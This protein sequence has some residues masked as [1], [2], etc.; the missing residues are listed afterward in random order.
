LELLQDFDFPIS[1]GKIR[2]TPDGKF[3]LASG[4]K[5]I[6]PPHISPVALTSEKSPR[7]GIYP[8]QIRIYEAAELSMKV[9]RH[10]DCEIVNFEV[11]SNDYSKLVLLRADR[12][13]EFHA[14]YGMYYET[15]I[16]KAGRDIAYHYPTCDLFAVGSTNEIYRLNLEQG[17]FLKP[18]ESSSPAVNVCGVN[19]A[20]GW[21]GFGGSDGT[22]ECWDPRDK[23]CSAALPITRKTLEAAQLMVAPQANVEISSFRWSN[24][25]IQLAIGTSTGHVLLYDMRSNAPMLT[26][27]HQFDTPIV[28]IK[29]HD[30]SRNVISSCRK[31]VRMWNRDTAEN[32][33][34]IEPG[35]DIN[36]VCIVPDSGL[37]FMATEQPK[38]NV[39]YI[40]DLGRAPEWCAFL[41]N[42]TEELEEDTVAT[43]YQDYKF[44]TREELDKLGVTRLIGTPYLRAYMHGFY[45]DFRLYSKIRSIARPDEY[46][47]YIKDRIKQKM[48]EKRSSRI[49]VN[50][51]KP[52][53]NQHVAAV[54]NRPEILEDP[55]FARMWSDNSMKV[56]TGSDAYKRIRPSGARRIEAESEEEDED[57]DQEVEDEK[58]PSSDEFDLVDGAQADSD[59]DDESGDEIDDADPSPGS[60]LKRKRPDSALEDE[61]A[62]EKEIAKR[63]TKLRF[64]EARESRNPLAQKDA[65]KRRKLNVAL[66][67][68]VQKEAPQSQS[69]SRGPSGAL[70]FTFTPQ[71]VK[72]RRAQTKANKVDRRVR[73]KDR[74]PAKALFGRKG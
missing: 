29:F 1:G 30:S 21:M 58:E 4:T 18:W 64:F 35:V 59:A 39:Y 2:T 11:L 9:K 61:D 8:P 27:D 45:M 16:P 69:R 47:E 57:Q 54:T 7:V 66:G 42:L 33:A 13:I 43:Q 72:D 55:R 14:K 25:G 20:Y 23:V 67:A 37:V 52:K 31:I 12:T 44:V 32:C 36:D 70:S 26:K 62:E 71:D 24:D 49:S 51:G 65:N 53:V 60:R 73:N 56:D 40:P 3:I 28:D 19:P 15:R 22:F 74:R 68:R 17:K 50:R 34:Y 10:V 6:N 46:K 5:S 63:V 38:M 41:D 48:E